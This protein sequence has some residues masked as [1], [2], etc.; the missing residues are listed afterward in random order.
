[1]S[2][3]CWLFSKSILFF[4]LSFSLVF[5]NR[6][7]SGLPVQSEEEE[8]EKL[9][10]QA[11]SYYQRGDYKL[12]IGCYVEAAALTQSKISL[13]RA[14]FGLA[15]SY[16]YLRDT[17]NSMKWMRK[18]CEVDPKK[19]ISE[20]FYPRSFVQLFNQ[21]QREVREKKAVTKGEVIRQPSLP[22]PEKVKEEPR[23]K[24]EPKQKKEEKETA[25]PKIQ[26]PGK[27]EPRTEEI[28]AL[29]EAEKG[30]NFE[31]GVHYSLWSINLI[32]GLFEKD[33]KNELGEALQNEI[34]KKVGTSHAGLVKSNFTPSLT[35]DSEG[36][37]YG[38]EVRYYSRGRA[39]TFSIGLSLEK[40]AMKLSVSGNVKQD[41]TNGSSA[42]VNAQAYVETSPFSTNVS[43]RWDISSAPRITPY[44]VFGFGYA[45]LKGKFFYTYTGNYQFQGNQEKLED[46]QTKN[47][48]ELSED[49]DFDIPKNIILV[50]I[51]FGIKVKISKDFYLMGEAGIWDGFLLRAGASYRF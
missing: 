34:V 9:L 51:N 36:S 20:L 41:F 37:N 25:A 40:T 44:F 2:C 18:V 1:M 26:V 46:T 21:V 19:E 42:A 17:L 4:L 23:P 33:L 27:P 31:I 35:L 10:I 47:L 15:L 39:G 28:K 29:R 12:A 7:F 30:G 43:F 50:Q 16:F 32:K 3:N 48:D 6:G 11:D 5:V 22:K 13:S 8:V 14:Y 38:L 24:E 45:P 49:I